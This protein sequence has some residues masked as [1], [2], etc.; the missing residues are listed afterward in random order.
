MAKSARVAASKEPEG[1][2]NSEAGGS[3]V[4]LVFAVTSETLLAT[5]IGA[6]HLWAILEQIEAFFTN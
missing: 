4:S 2:D 6:D 5:L 3:L 1:N